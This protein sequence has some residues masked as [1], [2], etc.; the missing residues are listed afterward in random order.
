[1]INR[2]FRI[3]QPL[4]PS[5][6]D[7]V[8]QFLFKGK[9]TIFKSIRRCGRS[10]VTWVYFAIGQQL[11]ASFVSFKDLEEAYLKWLTTVDILQSTSDEKRAIG[12]ANFILLKVGEPVFHVSRKDNK[13]GV[14]T[15]KRISER[16]LPLLWVD[17]G[18]GLPVPEQP[19]LVECF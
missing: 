9:A 14:I 5:Q 17:W 7:R 10:G 16:K 8:L 19:E 4:F 3:N 13:L 11:R 15:E 1:M 12:R 6:F 18:N 2:T